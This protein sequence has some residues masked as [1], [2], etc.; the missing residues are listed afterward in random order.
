[1][2]LQGANP[3]PSFGGFGL[4]ERRD[5]L[6]RSKAEAQETVDAGR[7]ELVS[8]GV[9]LEYLKDLK[10]VLDYG[11][12]SERRALLKS[13]VRS[14]ERHDSGVTVRYTLPLPPETE[15]S[16]GPGVLDSVLVGGPKWTVDRTIFELWLGGL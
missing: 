12:V 14:V 9:V 8:R 7:V 15:P 10:G 16:G 1:M 11:S 6:L 2:P 13:F 5:L 4:R 3:T